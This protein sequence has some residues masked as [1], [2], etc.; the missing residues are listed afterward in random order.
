[1][2]STTQPEVTPAVSTLA[3]T[4]SAY[5]HVFTTLDMNTLSKILSDDYKHE[6]APASTNL[7][8]PIDRDAYM[9]RLNLIREVMSNF[10]VKIRQTWPNPS[11]R[12]VLVWA[13]SETNFHDYLRDNDDKEEWKMKGEYMFLLT[14][15]ESGEK[16][17]HAL[18]FL[19]SKATADITDLV[20]RAINRKKLLSES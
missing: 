14:M 17:E 1:M 7:P 19:D 16:V 6:F 12:Q 4:A 2:S 5:I 15:D 9:A 10:P 20:G 13:D 3:A 18:E 11:L 8:G